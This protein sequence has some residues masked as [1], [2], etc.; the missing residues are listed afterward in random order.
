VA[1]IKQAY[2]VLLQSRLNTS[3]AL[4]KLE[5][6]GPHTPE[7]RGLVEFI[8]SSRRGVILKR[9]RRRAAPDEDES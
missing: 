3:A 2:R 7:V 5:A 4:A 9:H 1:A 6:E 8:R